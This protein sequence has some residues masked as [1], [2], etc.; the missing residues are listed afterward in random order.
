MSQDNMRV[1]EKLVLQCRQ[2]Y[3]ARKPLI[4]VDTEDISLMERLAQ[5]SGVVSLF[6]RREVSYD[7]KSLRYYQYVGEY[8]NDLAKA[9]NYTYLVKDLQELAEQGSSMDY[10]KLPMLLVAHLTQKD[11]TT[12]QY[13]RNYV[14]AYMRC[15]DNR[16]ALRS[17]C[18]LLY[19]DPGFLPKDLVCHTEI[20]TVE[21][22]TQM[23]IK[24]LLRR[25]AD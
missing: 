19:G 1:M 21:Y 24:E 4:L 23:E 18:V 7:P 17:S 16:T 11:S 13:L 10:E 6:R 8:P 3:Y 22:P 14:H 9:E 2:A 5:E 20:L 25:L 12:E 15:R